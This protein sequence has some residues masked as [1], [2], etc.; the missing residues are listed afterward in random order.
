MPPYKKKPINYYPFP[1]TV[2]LFY[3]FLLIMFVFPIFSLLFSTIL[4]M[5]IYLIELIILLSLFGSSVNIPIFT[6]KRHVPVVTQKVVSFMGVPWIVPELELEEAK[7]IIAVNLG[8]CI[9]PVTLSLYIIY[10]LSLNYGI[11]MLGF[12]IIAIIIDSLLINAVAKPVPGVGIATP[13]FLPPL[14]TALVTLFLAPVSQGSAFFAFAYAVGT[15]S[16]LIGA[17]L[18]NLKKIP[19]LGAPI[20]SIGGAGTFDGVFLTGLISILF[21]I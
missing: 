5:P 13:S 19:R 18:M 11:K 7:T 2:L 9:I 8:G 3:L 15:L 17:D 6:M 21:L 10:Q 14:F 1:P 16:A 12:I 4:G 20:A